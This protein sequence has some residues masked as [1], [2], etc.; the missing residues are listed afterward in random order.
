M[1]HAQANT[2]G[3][4]AVLGDHR[5]DLELQFLDDLALG[6]NLRF[7][8]GGLDAVVLL[9][10]GLLSLLNE[11][12]GKPLNLRIKQHELNHIILAD[13]LLNNELLLLE[14][15]PFLL[16]LPLEGSDLALELEDTL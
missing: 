10:N 6:D 2:I 14:L 8:L 1:V 16:D 3:E 7:E 9:L 12:I 4:V 15:V 13:L 5:G 11:L